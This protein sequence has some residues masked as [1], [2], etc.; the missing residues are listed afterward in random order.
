MNQ[1][2]HISVARVV[3]V[4]FLCIAVS[5]AVL[6]YTQITAEPKVEIKYQ[7][8]PQ[9]LKKTDFKLI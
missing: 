6:A 5:M 4:L 7:T 3:N 8:V 9:P 1:T 2:I